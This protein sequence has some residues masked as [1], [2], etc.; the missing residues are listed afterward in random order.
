VQE[1]GAEGFDRDA[2]TMGRALPSFPASIMTAALHGPEQTCKAGSRRQMITPDTLR[3]EC[4]KRGFQLMRRIC[5][6]SR[7]AAIAAFVAALDCGV[8]AWQ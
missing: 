6:S 2:N 5:E 4:R 1:A 8:P 7:R 3:E